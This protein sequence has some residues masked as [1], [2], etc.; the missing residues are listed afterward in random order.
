M[1]TMVGLYYDTWHV[2]Y[3]YMSHKPTLK[4]GLH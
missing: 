3:M 1:Q 4:T 2:Q